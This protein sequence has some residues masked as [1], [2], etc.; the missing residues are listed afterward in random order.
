MPVEYRA[1]TTLVSVS[2][3]LT[4]RPE[5]LPPHDHVIIC[6]GTAHAQRG[7]LA[8]SKCAAKR[9]GSN[10]QYSRFDE[11]TGVGAAPWTCDSLARRATDGATDVKVTWSL[12]RH[13]LTTWRRRDGLP[14][15]FGTI[16][17]TSVF[18]PIRRSITIL[19]LDRRHS[20]VRRA[21][22]VD[23]TWLRFDQ[24]A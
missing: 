3:I 18:R 24:L 7:K 11:R 1:E 6:Y 4:T 5:R 8:T 21:I 22:T 10:E 9:Y 2:S 12:W 19:P 13:K 15:V 23:V 16:V 20:L 14:R 17:L